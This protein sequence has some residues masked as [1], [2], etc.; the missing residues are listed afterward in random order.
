VRNGRPRHA[1]ST[2]RLL[3]AHGVGE[4]PERHD[5]EQALLLVDHGHATDAVLLHHRLHHGGRVS[6]RTAL[7][8]ACH[9]AGYARVSQGYTL[10]VCGHCQVAIRDDADDAL[11]VIDDY[12]AATVVL[13]HDL[14]CHAHGV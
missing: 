10:K 5:A 9:C 14:R 11:V 3:R 12:D 8:V 4:V 6:G 1:V 2:E 13:P 7:D